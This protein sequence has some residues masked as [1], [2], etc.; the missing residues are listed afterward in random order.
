MSQANGNQLDLNQLA[1][2]F[3]PTIV[4]APTA[5]NGITLIQRLLNSTRK[6]IIFGENTQLM[7]TLPKIAATNH[8]IHHQM[9]QGLERSRQK[10]LN[11]TSDYW[12][13]DLWP[14][15]EKFMMLGFEMFYKAAMIYRQSAS[16]YGFPQW[17]IK[18]PMTQPQMMH[19][20]AQLIKPARF[21]VVYRNPFDVVAS[22]KAR[23]F[24]TDQ[25]QVANYAK[26]WRDN[27]QAVRDHPPQHLMLIRHETL[28]A[29]PETILPELERF[30]GVEGIDRAVLERK[31]NT[32]AGRESDGHAADQ[33]IAPAELT[34]PECDLIREH[35]G[36]MLAWAGYE[37]A[38]DQPAPET[39]PSPAG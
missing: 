11:E 2:S 34:T 13:S 22:A 5:R 17:G 33:Y 9:G 29:E 8:A 16:E 21:V 31:I 18:N 26:Q 3:R 20:L 35:A 28:A 36:E 14:S 23:Q 7:E 30:A 15:T 10:F 4:T 39:A 27:L 38:A 1:N 37:P 24:I 25:Q 19:T 6:T 32:F 12:S